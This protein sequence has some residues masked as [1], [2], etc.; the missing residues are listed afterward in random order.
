MLVERKHEKGQHQMQIVLEI[1]FSENWHLKIVISKR[2]LHHPA[3]KLFRL[4]QLLYSQ[5]CQFYHK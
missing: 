2:L 5:I 1:I 4:Y 3:V